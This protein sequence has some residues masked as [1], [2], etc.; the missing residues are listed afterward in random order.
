M[1]FLKGNMT[2]TAMHSATMIAITMAM[3]RG[4]YPDARIF[5]LWTRP[6]C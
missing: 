5:G 2:T 6:M 1:L 3:S 4:R